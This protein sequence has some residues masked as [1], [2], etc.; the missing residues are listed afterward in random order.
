MQN[1]Y[2]IMLT[3]DTML[4]YAAHRLYRRH[5][6]HAA[7]SVSLLIGVCLVAFAIHLLGA[8]P[9]AERYDIATPKGQVIVTRSLVFF[10]LI[11][12][13][14][15]ARLGREVVSHSVSQSLY[16]LD[17]GYDPPANT[18]EHVPS[19][20]A[21]TFRKQSTNSAAPTAKTTPKPYPSSKSPRLKPP[22]TIITRPSTSPAKSPE[23]L[24]TATPF[25]SGPPFA[26]PTS[27][28]S[29]S[30]T[31]LLHGAYFA[32]SPATPPP[33]NSETWH[34]SASLICVLVKKATTTP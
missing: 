27:T 17:T 11:P 18:A 32:K 31:F 21:A 2:A 29:T 22:S 1:E 19:K 14:L 33:Q 20:H 3:V 34:T 25:G 13:L 4:A 12:A 6:N 5:H 7:M 16:G 30:M 15:F 26:W 9:L 24:R 28:S 23:N 8:L 10:G